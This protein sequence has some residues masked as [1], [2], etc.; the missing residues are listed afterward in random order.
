MELVVF[1]KKLNS[2]KE[3]EI[4]CTN[5]LGMTAVVKFINGKEST[6]NNLTEFHHRFDSAMDK[7]FEP[8]SAFESDIH[9]TG[10][11]KRLSEIKSI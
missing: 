1:G 6:F 9:S 3:L 4:T 7:F 10:C 5:S 2:D 11:T 8:S